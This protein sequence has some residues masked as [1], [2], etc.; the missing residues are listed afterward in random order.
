[1]LSL[2]LPLHLFFEVI[3]DDAIVTSVDDYVLL[4]LV[5]LGRAKSEAHRDIDSGVP[6]SVRR[7]HGV[8]R[9]TSPGSIVAVIHYLIISLS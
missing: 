3:K 7:G 9:G 5:C 4:G 1:M 6:Q 2:N 8:P